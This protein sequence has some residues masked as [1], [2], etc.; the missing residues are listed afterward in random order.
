MPKMSRQRFKYLENKKSFQDEIKYIFHHF[1]RALTE[2]NET[3]FLEG[4]SPTLNV[5]NIRNINQ[6]I[7]FFTPST[8]N[9][10]P[11]Q[12]FMEPILKEEAMDI[13]STWNKIELEDFKASENCLERSKYPE[14]LWAFLKLMQNPGG[15]SWGSYGRI[16]I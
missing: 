7:F 3:I 4:E 12:F 11:W 13:E 9:L 8:E 2:T 14:N 15:R 10:K 5:K 16:T 6:P 1:W